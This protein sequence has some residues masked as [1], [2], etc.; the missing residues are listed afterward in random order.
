M[1]VFTPVAKGQQSAIIDTVHDVEID[2]RLDDPAHARSAIGGN[3][4]ISYKITSTNDVVK[5]LALLLAILTNLTGW[6]PGQSPRQANQPKIVT[7]LKQVI[8][9]LVLAQGRN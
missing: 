3:L 5:T 9:K 2:C 8:K 1:G 4:C 6:K 7:F